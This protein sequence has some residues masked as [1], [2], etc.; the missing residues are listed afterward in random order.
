[1]LKKFITI[2]SLIATFSMSPLVVIPQA[3]ANSNIVDNTTLAQKKTENTGVL[4][5]NNPYSRINLRSKP[6]IASKALGYGL[7]GDGV[8]IIGCSSEYGDTWLQVRFIKP[9]YATG[10]IR[11][12]L[13][14]TSVS[15]QYC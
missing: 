9:P 7:T 2:S 13:I 10:W 3:S 8:E 11:A 1:M 15:L 12:D 4:R 5:A 14:R 6:T